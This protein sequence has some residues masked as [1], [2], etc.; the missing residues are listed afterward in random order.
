MEKNET[1]SKIAQLL[2]ARTMSLHAKAIPRLMAP[3]GG[4]NPNE[5]G[6]ATKEG[7]SLL[8]LGRPSALKDSLPASQLP[9]Y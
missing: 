2:V 4:L 1:R 9:P 5:V 6:A 7:F 3:L 8:K